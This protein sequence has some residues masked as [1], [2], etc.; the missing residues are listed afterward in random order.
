MN[1]RT[2]LAPASSAMDSLR[3]EFDR[4]ID[5]VSTSGL[6]SPWP[7]RVLD[8]MRPQPS[9]NLLETDDALFFESEL[10]GVCREDL[11]I[12]AS[13]HELT[14]A[15]TRTIDTPTQATTLRH[16]RSTLRFERTLRLPVA[17]EAD[18]IDASLENGV[19]TVSLPKAKPARTRRIAVNAN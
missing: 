13:D 11:D 17:V 19:L 5:R 1:T 2:L 16:E 8:R 7:T 18:G 3:H 9:V 10:P 12:S 4:L 14:I 6:A 15:G